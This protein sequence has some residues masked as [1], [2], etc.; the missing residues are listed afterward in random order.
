MKKIMAIAAI[1]LVCFCLVSCEQSPNAASGLGENVS[2]RATEQN[3]PEFSSKENSGKDESS[4]E[5]NAEGN[6]GLPPY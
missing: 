5:E 3:A 1:T 2:V 4:S 6:S